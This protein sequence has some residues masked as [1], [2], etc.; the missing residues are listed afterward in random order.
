MLRHRPQ[1]CCTSHPRRG[2]HVYRR[3]TRRRAACF[4][5]RAGGLRLLA[6][7]CRWRIVTPS[8][9]ITKLLGL[10]AYANSSSHRRRSRSHGAAE[11]MVALSYLKME[12]FPNIPTRRTPLRVAVYAPLASAPV[13][14]DVVLVRGNAQQLMLL[15]QAAELAGVD[16][17]DASMGRP[18]CALLLHAINSSRTAASFRLH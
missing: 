3:G 9:T 7:R 5:D 6:A 4:R 13:P 2:D 14:P 11:T 18:T 17:T 15:S 12:E 8:P 16:G 1:S 10:G